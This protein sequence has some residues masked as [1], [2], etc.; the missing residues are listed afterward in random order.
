MRTAYIIRRVLALIPTLLL[1]YTITFFLMHSTPGGPWDTGEKP[2]PTDVQERLKAA[3]GLDKPLW[4][5]YGEFLG[6]AVKGDLGPSYTQRSR[7]VV[8]I[9]S[10]TFPVSLQ[11]AA[12]ATAL[13]VL[14]GVPLGILGAVRHNR[15]LDYIS[16]FVSVFGISTPAYVVT[17]LLVL[18]LASKLRLLPTSG[19]DGIR[20]PKVIIPALSL[21]LYPMA[22][23]ARYTRSSMLEVLRTD[24]LRTARAKG[25]AERGVIVRHALRNALL[26]VIT[27]AGIVLAD[28][29]T[30]SFF[31]ETIYQV[32]GVGRY[33]VQSISAR[34]YPVILGTVLLL[35][36]VVSVMNLVVDLLYP[37]LDPRIGRR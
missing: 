3:Y 4:Q 11:L 6:N 9:L 36:L 37:L 29:A 7:T 2:I 21:A 1:I 30:G 34:D 23:L 10:E 13:A 12:V 16:T 32:P 5:Q 35:G 26:P 24:Y 20:S 19:W 28:I 31:V 15:P 18:I 27:I 17:S 33:F 14:I 22:V 25:I 8:Q